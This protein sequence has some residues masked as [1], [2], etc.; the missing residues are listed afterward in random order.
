MIPETLF[1]NLARFSA[2][3]SPEELERA[4][5]SQALEALLPV[6]A[7]AEPSTF[8][9]SRFSF[10]RANFSD[11]AR[12]SPGRL[13]QLRRLAIEAG[14]PAEPAYRVFRREVPL[15]QSLIAGSQP[16][17]AG[18][19]A[20]ELSF[21]PFLS[22]DGR[23]FWFDLFPIIRLIPLYLA[24]QPNPALLFYLPQLQQGHG[25]LP[26]I[27]EILPI[28][29]RPRVNLAGSS[30]WVRADLLADGSPAGHYAGF[31]INTGELSFS[32]KPQDIGGKLTLP[33]DA[34]C[35]VSLKLSH[36]SAPPGG[37]PS[38]AGRDARNANLNLPD[39]LDFQFSLQAHSV[40]AAGRGRWKVYGQD[41]TFQ[42]NA[43]GTPFYEPS[44]R[45]ALIPYN[46][47]QEEFS[48]QSSASPFATVA[49]TAAVA[50][51]AWAI[52]LA[53]IDVN[54]PTPP[55]GNG[56]MAVQT[57][58]GL[59]ITWRGLRNG[60][61]YLPQP[62][63]VL[64]PGLL[65]IVDPKAGN[66]HARQR[67]LL[68]KDA[69]APFRS[70]V[71]LQYTDSFPL[72]YVTN[73]QGAEALMANADAEARLDRP[74]D[75]AGS[76]LDIR[77]KNSLLILGFTDELQL[78]YL[79]DDNIL[80]DNLDLQQTPAPQLPPPIALAIRNALFTA[81]PVNGFLLF[82]ELL[83]EEMVD[84]GHVLLVMGLYGLLPTLPDPYAA[85]VGVFRRRS[86]RGSAVSIP[87]ML[88]L[89]HIPWKKAP[90]DEPD[91]VAVNFH[92]APLS[93]SA[94]A[95]LQAGA[96]TPAT[97]GT[98]AQPQS[99]AFN[100]DSPRRKWEDEWDRRFQR[101]YQ[102]QFAL[103]DVSTNADWMGVSFAW[104][105]P[106][107]VNDRDYVFYQVYGAQQT[108]DQTQSLFPLQ[109]QGLDLISEGRFV[110]AFTTPQ[111]SW[112]PYFN[113]TPPQVT[114]DPP[115]F[116][117]FF[118]NDGGPTRLFNDNKESVPV[119]PLP[120]ID[121]LLHYF[122]DTAGGFTG[123]LFTLPFGMKAFAEFNKNH[124]YLPDA[125]L[126][127]NQS[128]F[129]EGTLKGGLQI[130]A[131]A[132]QRVTES[133][134]FI[135]G[136][137]QLNNLVFPNGTP[138]GAGILGNSVSEIFNNEFFVLTNGYGDRGVPLERIDF[139]GYG[140]G[141]FSRWENPE[142][143]F[144]E[145]S[146]ARFDVFKGR[147]AHEVI[148]V[149]SV[150]YPWGIRVV[151]T[152]VVFRVGSGYV[153]RYD[154]G[155]QAE[156]PGLY[157]FSYRVKETP[158]SQPVKRDNPFEIHPGIVKGV[159]NV[160][161][162]TETPDIPIFERVWN[163]VNGD[164]YIDDAGVEQTVDNATPNEF[165]NP[166]VKLQPVYFDADVDIEF[167]K[168]GAV[169]GKV[170]SKG[171]L[172]YV[173]LGP[174]GQPI[175]DFLFRD[176]LREQFGSLGG[177]V[178]CLI[179]IGDTGQQMRLSRVD[180]SE[181]I[182]AAGSKPVFAGTARGSAVLPKDG[183]WS[184]VRYQHGNGEVSPLPDAATVPLIRKGLLGAAPSPAD[185]LRLENPLEL[186]R[187]PQADS[188]F[189]GLLQTTGTQKALFRKP[190][191]KKGVQELLSETPDFADA[192]RMLNSAGIFPNLQDGIPLD[193][194][195][196]DQDHRGGFQAARRGRSD[197]GFGK[198]PA[199]RAVVH[200]R[201]GIPQNLYRIR[202]ARQGRQ[203]DQRRLRQL[204]HRFG[205]GRYGQALAVEDEQHRHG[206]RSRTAPAPA[207]G[208]GQVRRGKRSR[209]Q[210][211]RARARI[212]RRPAAGDRHPA[213]PAHAARRRL[214]LG[215]LQGVGSRH[216]QYGGKLVVRL[217]RTQGDTGG[218][219]PAWAGLR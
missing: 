200:H 184:V 144:A 38:E 175:P 114:G 71:E 211:R 5:F 145:T 124:A 16:V 44:L 2:Q 207:D 75:V 201:R 42:W 81:T 74:V 154:T 130:R 140:A 31:R 60:P 99:S 92:F 102:E 195:F 43:Q 160:R 173:Q 96:T 41:T 153:Y 189:F 65:T 162:I 23:R 172:G 180:V 13:D 17:W 82:A 100:P 183:A 34:V 182:D 109:V 141:I 194:G 179:D 79:Y 219:I 24:G 193:L 47:N 103:L 168:S 35:S 111:I 198:S 73:A 80:I 155:W 192:Y 216:E 170:P 178:D 123:A 67:F 45:C 174:K 21:G 97:T 120:K 14:T 210:L 90:D 181:S 202:Q 40:T 62:W 3:F 58:E 164:T 149:K 19:A 26:P 106:R 217:P 52:P 55:G 142:A 115:P 117:N 190:R 146:Q 209:P 165:K 108:G 37:P 125:K 133:A 10:E 138:T 166:P 204:R 118:P 36:D 48:V 86:G 22:S 15:A 150:V 29:H 185:P 128:E 25:A 119:A 196:Q 101:F 50:Q 214:R 191:F 91:T 186:V 131:D 197:Q 177:P 203:Q 161:N 32:K 83:D 136:T 159:Y 143:A 51:S 151:R 167:T 169:Q 188:I 69:D 12:I 11:R 77:S 122:H 205:G 89:C 213:N 176:L 208:Q 18:G 87:I 112:E 157:D 199:R 105:N 171:M 104:F 33:A 27:S 70:S 88:L 72:Y 53:A 84:T 78:V 76:A 1:D 54:Q 137:L 116:F 152:I 127:L 107:T 66:L 39:N 110:R 9:H 68:W 85:N 134:M 139:S 206:R 59:E 129:R 46:A 132:P 158:V 57:S 98:P 20:P 215:F 4:S 6:L 63:I 56:G 148:Q 49:G 218:Q 163:K 121:E 61:I 147:T 30:I 28:L 7:A 64:F 126:E 95:F 135:G 94:Y 156:T 187:N 8:S 113:L 93:P 212:Q